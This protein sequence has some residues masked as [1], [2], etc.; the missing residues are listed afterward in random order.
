MAPV[1]PNGIATALVEGAAGQLDGTDSAPTELACP[2][3]AEMAG[4]PVPTPAK[5]VDAS[6]LV[7]EPSPADW[8]APNSFAAVLTARAA[9]AVLPVMKSLESMLIGIVAIRKGVLRVFSIDSDDVDDDDDV[10]SVADDARLCKVWGDARLCRVWG[11]PEISCGPDDM[12][13][14]TS[15]PPEVPAACP[16]SPPEL[17]VCGGVANG[18]TCAAVAEAPAYPYIAAA[19]WAHI[20]P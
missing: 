5:P 15:V 20:S 7:L 9:F 11:I 17:V 1:P 14:S 19:S 3:P 10:E 6:T 16:V 13:V 8:A 4:V 18:V 12:S 2:I